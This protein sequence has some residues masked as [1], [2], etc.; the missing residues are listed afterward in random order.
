MPLT[1]QDVMIDDSR[2]AGALEIEI[3]PAMIEAGVYEARE[4]TLGEKLPYLVRK[5]FI[6]MALAASAGQ[7][8][9]PLDH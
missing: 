4:H 9:R 8:L 6:A 1:T 7:T 5:I 3:T 2:Q